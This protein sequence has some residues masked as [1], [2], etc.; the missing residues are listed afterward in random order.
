MGIN[1]K[2]MSDVIDIN[3]TGDKTE[4]T[5]AEPRRQ[6][7]PGFLSR[8]RRDE[9]RGA[10]LDMGNLEPNIIKP[11]K[12]MVWWLLGVAIVVLLILIIPLVF[13]SAGINITPH[14]ESVEI[15]NMLGKAG[16][17]DS[18]EELKYIV[19]TITG[20]ASVEVPASGKKIV[21][22]HATG[23]IMLENKSTSKL[24][25]IP[26][27][28]FKSA[29]GL[30]YRIKEGI[31]LPAGDADKPG[32][33]KVAVYAD[34]PGEE[35]NTTNTSFVVPGLAGT[36]EFNNVSAKTIGPIT[37]GFNGETSVISDAD[38]DKAEK[39]LETTLVERLIK[40]ARNQLPEDSVM[41][42]D[43]F[44]VALEFSEN[45]ISEG[46]NPSQANVTMKGSLYVMVLNDRDLSKYIAR[47]E[48]ASSPDADVRIKNWQDLTFSME[49][50]SEIAKGGIANFS[51]SGTTL[52][53]WNIDEKAVKEALAGNKRKDYETIF[54]R[55]DGIDRADAWVKPFWKRSFPKDPEKIEVELV[56]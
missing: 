51:I 48:L 7:A 39:S 16:T 29:S 5:S 43:G 40:D 19:L 32:L 35:Y 33:L 15:L 2:I 10:R 21:E 53:S 36:P 54:R 37:G 6:A 20:D 38:L 22:R 3:K 12:K 27:T 14:T 56:Y 42:D 55:F 23:T 52:F 8:Q 4:T 25:L 50:Y 49:D 45:N 41:F 18:D 46:T 17:S 9:R 30:E 34:K 1:D 24:R 11:K 13:S 31:T 28:R 47:R 26:K 44:S